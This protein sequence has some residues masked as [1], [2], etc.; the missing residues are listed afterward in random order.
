MCSQQQVKIKGS[1]KLTL[2]SINIDGL[3]C[4][5]EQ[6]VF[7]SDITKNSIFINRIIDFLKRLRLS[8]KFLLCRF[9][10]RGNPPVLLYLEL[11]PIGDI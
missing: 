1:Q 5:M 9:N 2:F 7:N 4:F 11:R 6:A 8:F 3:R 10:K